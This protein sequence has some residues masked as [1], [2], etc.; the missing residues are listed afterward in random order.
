MAY[1]LSA[2]ELPTA[3]AARAVGARHPLPHLRAHETSS[4]SSTGFRYDAHPMGMLLGAV[5]ALSTFYP[6]AKRHP[7]SAGNRYIQQVRLMR[8]AA[9]ASPSFCYPPRHAASRTSLPATTTSTTSAT[10]ST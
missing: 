4:S 5:G 1:L 2:G 3:R 10:S 7:R 9:D 6:D 8:E